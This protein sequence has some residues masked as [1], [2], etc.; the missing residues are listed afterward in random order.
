M[1]CGPSNEASPT[2]SA[3]SSSS[4]NLHKDCLNK[5][6]KAAMAA[7]SSSSSG[8]AERLIM[9]LLQKDRERLEAKRKLKSKLKEEGGELGVSLSFFSL[10]APRMSGSFERSATV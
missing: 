3:R 10:K 1:F 8:E 6:F 9:I 2:A 5:V 7:P 4:F